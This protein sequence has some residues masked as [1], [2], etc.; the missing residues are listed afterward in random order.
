MALW[1][2]RVL[3][4]CAYEGLST[5]PPPPT[6]GAAMAVAFELLGRDGGASSLVVFHDDHVFL[7][8]YFAMCM[9]IMRLDTLHIFLGGRVLGTFST[10]IFVCSLFYSL[11]AP[12]YRQ[13]YLLST[14]KQA[15]QLKYGFQRVLRFQTFL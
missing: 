2:G 7:R 6:S 1:D 11:G 10:Y 9:E 13:M 4:H 14:P 8:R 15:P 3:F 5:R 12:N